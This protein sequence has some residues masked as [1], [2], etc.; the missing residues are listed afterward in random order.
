[1]TYPSVKCNKIEAEVPRLGHFFFDA[2]LIEE[3]Q[4]A[5]AMKVKQWVKEIITAY[6]IS[7]G[8]W[9]FSHPLLSDWM[10]V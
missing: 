9:L 5:A 2:H 6:N 10:T 4:F 7:L 8:D 3:Q 1:M